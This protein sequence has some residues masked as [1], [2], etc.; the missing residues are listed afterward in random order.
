MYIYNTHN[1]QKRMYNR[2]CHKINGINGFIS[3]NALM[4]NNELM[5]DVHFIVGPPGESQKVPAHKVSLHLCCY[6]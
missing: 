6:V 4:F 2:L 3:R 5:A 1:A